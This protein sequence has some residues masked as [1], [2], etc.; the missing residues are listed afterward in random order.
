MFVNMIM[1][2][3][4]ANTVKEKTVALIGLKQIEVI[5]A[6]QAWKKIGEKAAANK[7]GPEALIMFIKTFS[8]SLGKNL[9]KRKALQA[10]PAV[11]AIVAASMN[12]SF[13]QDVSWAARRTFQKRWLTENEK[14][15]LVEE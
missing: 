6:K 3:A 2:A 10:I 7:L 8:K 4:N 9:T 15:E 11:G 1:S 13:I 12:V 5:I 14:I